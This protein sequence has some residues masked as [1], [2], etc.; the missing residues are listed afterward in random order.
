VAANTAVPVEDA[1]KKREYK[2]MEE[3]GHGDLHAKVDMNTVSRLF[4]R[5]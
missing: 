1:P 2:D 3:K 5:V 4:G